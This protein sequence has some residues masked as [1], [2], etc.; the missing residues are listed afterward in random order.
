MD[1]QLIQLGGRAVADPRRRRVR[2][3]VHPRIDRS[4][5]P[6][7]AQR[8]PRVHPLDDP[9][10]PFARIARPLAVPRA[11]VGEDPRTDVVGAPLWRAVHREHV[12]EVDE[13]EPARRGA[14]AEEDLLHRGRLLERGIGVGLVPVVLGDAPFVS[15]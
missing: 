6:G 7:G 9:V 3:Q 4:I 14:R 12:A 2:G 13:E 1:G 15:A 10:D 11:P 8:V 5:L